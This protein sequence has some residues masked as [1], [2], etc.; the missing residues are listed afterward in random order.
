MRACWR[1][2]RGYWGPILTT[3][4]RHTHYFL[5]CGILKS[6]APLCFTR[7]AAI[8]LFTSTK[9]LSFSCGYS[10][11]A[12]LIWSM[13][14]TSVKLR[15][16]GRRESRHDV[17]HLSEIQTLE[18]LA[19]GVQHTTTTYKRR[20]LWRCKPDVR[21]GPQYPRMYRQHARNG[22]WAGVKARASPR[23]KRFQF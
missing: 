10:P 3:I 15:S 6:F 18:S 2:I 19:T 13:N 20:R 11:K 16:F 1:Y 7:H 8:R 9:E 23:I 4:I 21:I 12:S 5:L 14:S 22:I 17:R